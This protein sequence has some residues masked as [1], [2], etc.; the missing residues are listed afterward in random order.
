[1]IHGLLVLVLLA[2]PVAAKAQFTYATNADGV[3]LTITGYTGSGRAVNIPSQINN[4]T[5]T[6]IGNYAF[7]GRLLT[8]VTIPGSV[9]NIGQA[10]F[11]D[12]VSL[13]SLTISNGVI[14]IGDGA[15]GDCTCL[16]N[17]T[18]PA[19][20]LGIGDS[21]FSGC[22][23]LTSVFFRGNPP[24]ADGSAFFYDAN[25]TVYYWPGTIGWSSPFGGRPAVLWNPVIQT[26]D[27]SFGIRNGQ[28]G[29]NITGTTNI[30]ILVEA[31]TNLANPVWTPLKSLALT[32]GSFY[33][34]EPFQ[35]NSS[36]R[37]YRISSP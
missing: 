28:L 2:A 1:M 15:F 37:F 33:F 3:S 21:A 29:F 31:S 4:L 35:A 22:T 17:I 25:T 6:S 14:S 23:S 8:N 19:S 30:P 24:N 16:T 5:V 26:G 18:I 11:E 32:N 20:V 9:S 12:C 34:S 13:S 10:A 36:G 7:D 27:S